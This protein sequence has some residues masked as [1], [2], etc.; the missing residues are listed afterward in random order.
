DL[1]IVVKAVLDR[2]T[3]ADSGIRTHLTHRGSQHVRRRVTQHL[4]RLGVL[5]R[6]NLDRRVTLQRPREI[7]HLAIHLGGDGRPG[8]AWADCLGD[9]E[10][11]G[12][13]MHRAL[14]A[15][16]EGDADLLSGVYR[17]GH[18]SCSWDSCAQEQETTSP[19]RKH[20]GGG[21]NRSYRLWQTTRKGP[22][23]DPS[24]A[25]VLRRQAKLST[26]R[27]CRR[28]PAW[29]AHSPSPASRP[30]HSRW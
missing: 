7:D 4:E 3:E 11:R 21:G 12:T 8:E 23:R 14:R 27:P 28:Q 2:G 17:L 19:E 5:L 24:R 29:R 25:L 15:V 13:A 10:N 26:S 16:G 1:E 6:Q 30:P 9:L 22:A 18:S 20:K